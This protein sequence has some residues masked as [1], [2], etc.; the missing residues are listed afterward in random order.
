MSILFY[1]NEATGSWL[2]V[3]KVLL[4]L[5][6]ML[7]QLIIIKTGKRS[8]NV[9]FQKAR[10]RYSKQ[11]TNLLFSVCWTR[12]LP[13]FN[14][15]ELNGTRIVLLKAWKM[16]KLQNKN[17]KLSCNVS[18]VPGIKKQK[19][20]NLVLFYRST[21]TKQ[22]E[23]SIYLRREGRACAGQDININGGPLTLAS[24]P[25]PLVCGK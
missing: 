19:S 9:F 4:L 22:T 11:S 20:T 6:I 13:F 18:K 24:C 15:M 12:Y 5:L 25:L 17:E 14:I 1:C 8:T 21:P 3:L 7:L 23:S 10:P 2:V 16:K